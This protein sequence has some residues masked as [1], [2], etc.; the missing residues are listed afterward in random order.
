MIQMSVLFSTEWENN[1]NFQDGK[2]AK[3]LS[4]IF[5]ASQPPP[6]PSHDICTVKMMTITVIDRVLT[7]YGMVGGDRGLQLDDCVDDVESFIQKSPNRVKSLSSC[8][9]N[10]MINFLTITIISMMK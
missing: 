7:L 8:H 6:L 9:F 3:N 10:D 1:D 5:E 4:K 2:I